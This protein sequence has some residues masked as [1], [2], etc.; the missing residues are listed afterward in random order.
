MIEIK[1]EYL[2]LI[3]LLNKTNKLKNEMTQVT[4][5]V[6]DT[7]KQ[8]LKLYAALSAD[9]KILLCERIG[10]RYWSACR[11]TQFSKLEDFLAENVINY[12]FENFTNLIL[13]RIFELPD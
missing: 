6:D 3:K 7:N 12:S 9:Q 10:N 13:A 4:F 11:L 2:E 8:H 5:F 1:L